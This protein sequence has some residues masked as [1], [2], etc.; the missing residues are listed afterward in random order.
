MGKGTFLR[1]AAERLAEVTIKAE[2]WDAEQANKSQGDA[3][4]HV[5]WPLR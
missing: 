3:G 2:L 4:L 1:K 5:G